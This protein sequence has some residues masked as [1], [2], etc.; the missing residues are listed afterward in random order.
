MLSKLLGKKKK[1][2][3][4]LRFLME[5][6]SNLTLYSGLPRFCSQRFGIQLAITV[7]VSADICIRICNIR[8]KPGKSF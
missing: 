3:T 2:S 1:M 5:H 8:A 4:E 6:S 7:R